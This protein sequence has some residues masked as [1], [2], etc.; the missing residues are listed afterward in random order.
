MLIEK[1]LLADGYQ[2]PYWTSYNLNPPPRP[3]TANAEISVAS[4]FPFAPVTPD[5]R[6]HLDHQTPSERLNVSIDDCSSQE[7]DK[8]WHIVSSSSGENENTPNEFSQVIVDAASTAI[9][10]PLKEANVFNEIEEHVL[11]LNKTPDLKTPKK[12]KH[13]PKVVR[14]GKP[15]KVPKSAPPKT[16][17]PNGTPSGKRKY[18][19][20][21]NIK[22]VENQKDVVLN[23]VRSS[24]AES[25]PKSCRR[26]LNFDLESSNADASQNMRDGH[27]AV[28]RQEDKRPF[29][30]N[31]DAEDKETFTVIDSMSRT[32][33]CQMEQSR[34]HKEFIEKNQQTTS[35]FSLFRSNGQMSSQLKSL[36]EQRKDHTFARNLNMRN[37]APGQS[38]LTNEYI[39]VP[40][41]NRREELCQGVFQADLYRQPSTQLVMKDMANWNE[42]R[43]FKRSHCQTV[44]EIHAHNQNM[45]IPPFSSLGNSCLKNKNG[46]SS[47]IGTSASGTQKRLNTGYGL[48]VN[49]S[50]IHSPASASVYN[51]G[52]VGGDQVRMYANSGSP[53]LNCRLLNSG[54]ERDKTSKKLNC[55]VNGTPRTPITGKQN[56]QKQ[57][58]TIT[59]H[60]HRGQMTEHVYRYEASTSDSQQAI[61][62]Y[63]PHMST[64]KQMLEPAPLKQGSGR[65]EKMPLQQHNY[66]LQSYKPTPKKTRG[67]NLERQLWAPFRNTSMFLF[68]II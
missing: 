33:S 2:V 15:K 19:R 7:K 42:N 31:A 50:S 25:S 38:S 29:N 51:P 28:S 44:Q 23:E 1:L 57:Q 34:Q 58:A 6:K 46:D 60:A 18:V 62:G 12:R 45:T 52:Q 3:V 5:Q 48:H 43:G 26:A 68:P 32:S 8:Q 47:N 27:Q 17:V 35:T 22:T 40:E 53:E 66:A 36:T 65:P 30:L 24:A 20:K 21:K 4:S 61:V 13:R 59:L 55:S 41:H 11:D 63:N 37:A 56:Y 49:I 9:S 16:E 14:E 39:L 67:T 10:T 54:F 64:S